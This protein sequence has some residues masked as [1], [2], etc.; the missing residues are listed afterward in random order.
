M[1]SNKEIMAMDRN[2]AECELSDICH[3][4]HGC[5]CEECPVYAVNDEVPN[6]RKSRWGCDC[7]K[8]GSKMREFIK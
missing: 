1:Y 6:K 3:D 7:F 2:D 4:L 5:N 8:D